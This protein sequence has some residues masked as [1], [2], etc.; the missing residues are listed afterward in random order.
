MSFLLTDLAAR[1]VASLHEARLMRAQRRRLNAELASYR[2]AA[3]RAELGAILSRR[4][5]EDPEPPTSTTG[6]SARVA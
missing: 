3:E 5:A 2:T 6:P 1:R 4:T